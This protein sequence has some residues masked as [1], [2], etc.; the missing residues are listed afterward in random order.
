MVADV[1]G[2]LEV[3]RQQRLLERGLQRGAALGQGEVE[4]PVRVDRARVHGLEQPEREP[5]DRGELSE[6][7][8]HLAHLVLGAAVLAG[9]HRGGQLVAVLRGA[10]VE[11]EGAVD[12]L[13]LVGVLEL[14][15]RGLETALAHEAP[16][17]DDVA[18]DIDPHAC[19]N[20]RVGHRIPGFGKRLRH[21]SDT[22]G[23]TPTQG[24]PR[25]RLGVG[26]G[27]AS[28]ALPDVPDPLVGRGSGP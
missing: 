6:L 10:R 11:L 14:G 28:E 7:L 4:Q 22:G 20:G 24:L 5:L 27:D 13:H 1:L 26:P 19:A 16:R 25:G 21:S 23:E 9:Q 8:L 17:A 18:P 2:V 12:D 15:Q 3:R